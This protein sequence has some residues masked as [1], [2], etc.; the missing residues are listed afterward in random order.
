MKTIVAQQTSGA[1]GNISTE[2]WGSVEHSLHMP[3]AAFPHP[4]S[5]HKLKKTIWSYLFYR[6]EN[7]GYDNLSN[8][9]V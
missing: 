8:L 9:F 6:W 7:W 4:S 1:G 5:Q 3:G 2:K